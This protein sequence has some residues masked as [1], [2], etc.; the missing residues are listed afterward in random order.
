MRN[1][2][3]LTRILAGDDANTLPDQN[4]QNGK[5]GCRVEQHHGTARYDRYAVLHYAGQR[6]TMY[7]IWQPNCKVPGA[8]PLRHHDDAH[9][10][11]EYSE[12]H[13]PPAGFLLKRAADLS[14]ATT[15]AGQYKYVGV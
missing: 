9:R 6:D 3:R 15:K 14:H 11:H 10:Q 2:K 4:R 1:Q 8:V 13:T 12:I 5:N 7:S